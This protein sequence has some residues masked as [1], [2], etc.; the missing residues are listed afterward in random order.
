VFFS[1]LSDSSHKVL[2]VLVNN[3]RVHVKPM[4]QLYSILKDRDEPPTPDKINIASAKRQL[5]WKAEAEY[6]QKLEKLS[7]NIKKAFQNQ[8]AHAIVSGLPRVPPGISL[9]YDLTTG[10]MGPGEV[11]AST[12][13]VG[14]RM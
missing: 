12:Y 1:L 9:L 4:Y 7:E 8:Q 2:S 5:D 10:A 6:L 13:G 3:L 11:R 14:H